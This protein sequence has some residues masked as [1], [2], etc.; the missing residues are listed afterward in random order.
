MKFILFIISSIFYI[1]CSNTITQINNISN[2]KK[3]TNNQ[4]LKLPKWIQNPQNKNKICAIG[5]S[6]KQNNMKEIAQLKAKANIS[7]NISLYIQSQSIKKIKCNKTNCNDS[8]STNST[9]QSNTM[10]KD[11]KIINEYFDK[12]NN[13]YYLK[14]CINKLKGIK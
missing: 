7:K 11:V 8:F 10:L 3:N 13:I 6:K 12:Q 2:S 1:G 5:S 9:H 4:N 14:M